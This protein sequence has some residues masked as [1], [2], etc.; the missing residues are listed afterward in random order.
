MSQVGK[1][2]KDPCKGP[3]GLAVH[4]ML[5]SASLQA[6]IADFQGNLSACLLAALR[7]PG[8]IKDSLPMSVPRRE[9]MKHEYKEDRV[10]SRTIIVTF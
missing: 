1:R 3:P 7:I 6:D 9:K 4:A 10:M 5:H 8:H 2:K